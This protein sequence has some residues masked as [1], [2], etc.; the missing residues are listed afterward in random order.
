MRIIAC[1]KRYK[2]KTGSDYQISEDK[3]ALEIRLHY[4]TYTLLNDIGINEEHS[5]DTDVSPYE[6][7]I[8]QKIID[9][10]Y[11]WGVK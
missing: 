2:E 1:K 3:I 4:N 9:I 6:G 8:F 7:N 11:N 10:L 5:R